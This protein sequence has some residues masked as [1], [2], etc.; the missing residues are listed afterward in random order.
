MP[1]Q[2][3]TS[4]PSAAPAGDLET[5]FSVRS[6][7]C[8]PRWSR[9]SDRLGAEPSTQNDVPQTGRLSA[10]R[11]PEPGPRPSIRW[12][13]VRGG[14]DAGGA[15]GAPPSPA[16]AQPP[17]KDG[18]QCA[19]LGSGAGRRFLVLLAGSC[20]QIISPNLI[21][22]TKRPKPAEVRRAPRTGGLSRTVSRTHREATAAEGG[23]GSGD[24]TETGNRA[25]PGWAGRGQEQEQRQEDELK[26]HSGAT[27]GEDPRGLQPGLGPQGPP[28]GARL[29]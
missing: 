23:V 15:R 13:G 27:R 11:G 12:T 18:N 10:R 19:V 14:A 22:G 7:G 28:R 20:C 24:R 8:S 5:S 4:Y 25:G 1:R 6:W 21:L 2:E 9:G 16:L 3:G 26:P 29:P 17:S